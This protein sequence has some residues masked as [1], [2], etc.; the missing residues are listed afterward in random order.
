M[1]GSVAVSMASTS[2]A[3]SANITSYVWKS[4][5]TSI[6]LNSGVCTY[7]FGTASNTITLTVTDANGLTSTTTGNVNLRFL[8]PPTP[9]GVIGRSGEG[10]SGG[11]IS[12]NG[13]ARCCAPPH[14]PPSPGSGR[15]RLTPDRLKVENSLQCSPALLLVCQPWS[16]V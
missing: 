7:T 1:N 4:N 10:P 6:C 8:T 15:A 3:G 12:L 13:R 9:I 2:V 16:P 5:G 11:H 14:R